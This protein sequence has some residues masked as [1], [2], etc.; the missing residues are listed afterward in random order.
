ARRRGGDQGEAR[1]AARHRGDAARARDAHDRAR[2]PGRSAGGA[3][4]GGTPEPDA[5]PEQ[6]AGGAAGLAHA[7]EPRGAGRGIAALE[8]EASAALIRLAI[9]AP[10]E[11]ADAVLAELME[12]APEG[13]EEAAR[14][15]VVE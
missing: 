11:H 7:G 5:A 2:P 12:L 15:G 13:L 3:E 1:H 9:R 4:R 8:G 10:A 6:A 14:G